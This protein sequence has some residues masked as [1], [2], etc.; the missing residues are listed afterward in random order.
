MEE[1]KTV[2]IAAGVYDWLRDQFPNVTE[3]DLLAMVHSDF[4]QIVMGLQK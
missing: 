1:L 2:L 4:D 3:A